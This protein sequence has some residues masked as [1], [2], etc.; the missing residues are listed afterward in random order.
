[1]LSCLCKCLE[2]CCYWYDV[3]P[4]NNSD[5]VVAP[6]QIA[7]LRCEVHVPHDVNNNT[8]GRVRWYRSSDL[9]SCKDVT[10]K[11]DA[12]VRL[13]SNP[14]MSGNL[15]G[16]FK[17]TYTLIIRNITSSDNGYYL[18]QIITNETC[19]SQSPYVNI[20]VSTASTESSP[21][22][23]FDY[24]SNPVCATA[25][26]C[27]EPSEYLTLS[28]SSFAQP[29]TATFNVKLE[30]STILTTGVKASIVSTVDKSLHLTPT[31]L[32]PTSVNSSTIPST[33][34][35]STGICMTELDTKHMEFIACL[36]VTVPHCRVC[37]HTDHPV[38]LL[39]WDL[40]VSKEENQTER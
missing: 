33:H 27:D 29:A 18:C 13:A 4:G 24:G 2:Q 25:I 7:Y 32:Y 39:C 5:C 11:Y 9:I 19:L 34:P 15:A 17:D 30:S 10:D 22:P 20:S 35:A 3:V 14:F 40:C 21:C 26:T 38:H 6:D 36:G 23:S 31:S 12:Q 16:L 28:S 1:M 37:S 8:V